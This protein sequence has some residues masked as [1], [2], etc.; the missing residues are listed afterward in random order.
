MGKA[1][2]VLTL[3]NTAVPKAPSCE[4]PA[5]LSLGSISSSGAVTDKL[6]FFL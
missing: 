5:E 6:I 1:S 2:Q 4:V 3:A